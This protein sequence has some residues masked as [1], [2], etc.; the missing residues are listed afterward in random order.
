[1]EQKN[2][3]SLDKSEVYVGIALMDFTLKG[4]LYSKGKKVELKDKEVYISLIERGFI[5]TIDDIKGGN[6]NE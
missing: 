2:N 4:V 1:M 3:K 5:K 6:V